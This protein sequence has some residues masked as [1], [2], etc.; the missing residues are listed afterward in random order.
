MN[1]ILLIIV[2]VTVTLSIMFA[3]A[4]I[5]DQLIT[6]TLRI[7][8]KPNHIH[9]SYAAVHSKSPFATYEDNEPGH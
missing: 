3:A 8:R 7:I 9:K 2:V 1:D 5:M 6:R 4:L